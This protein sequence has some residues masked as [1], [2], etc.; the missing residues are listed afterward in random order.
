MHSFTRALN[1]AYTVAILLTMCTQLGQCGHD[2]DMYE[3]YFSKTKC[4]QPM[5]VMKKPDGL[6]SYRTR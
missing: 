2:E 6:A 3:R 5:F 1:Y 4:E